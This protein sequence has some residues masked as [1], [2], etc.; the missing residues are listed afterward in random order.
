VR[1][2]VDNIR[3]L[4]TVASLERQGLAEVLTDGHKGNLDLLISSW[5]LAVAVN[6]LEKQQLQMQV[7]GYLVEGLFVWIFYFCISTYEWS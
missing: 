1:V 3:D 5:A 7:I 6:E 4:E 2:H